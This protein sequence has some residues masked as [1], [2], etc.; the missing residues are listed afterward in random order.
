MLKY[1]FTSLIC[2]ALTGCIII[3]VPAYQ[4]EIDFPIVITS[5]S[6]NY[7][8]QQ[9]PILSNVFIQTH[10]GRCLNLNNQNG[11]ELL[12]SKC[13]GSF[14]QQFSFNANQEIMVNGKCLD[15]AGAQKQDGTP[16]IAYS[17]NGQLNQKWKL[18]NNKIY[19]L[20][21]GKCLDIYNGKIKIYSCNEN[22]GQKYTIKHAL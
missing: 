8:K 21:S 18:E 1:Y 22:K 19:S 15:V 13:N 4:D 5:P 6:P 14:N 10:D 3:E 9:A 11:R 2:L 12:A 7:P 16:I 20:H 17:C